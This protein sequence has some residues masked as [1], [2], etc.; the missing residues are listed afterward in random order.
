MTHDHDAMLWEALDGQTVRCNLCGHQCVIAAGKYGVCR[1][2]RNVEGKLK[3]LNYGALVALNADPIEKKPLFH[4]LPGTRSLSVAAAGCN[5]QCA[6]CQ[7]W[8]I[9]QAP[10]DGL[11]VGGATVSPAEI[12]AAAVEH[13]CPSISYTYTEPTVFFELAHDAAT[14]AKERGLKNCFVSNGFLSALAVETIAPVLDAI[15]VDLKA[16]RDATYRTIMKARLEPVLECLK[17][18]VKAGVWVEVTTLVV[19]GMNDSPEELQAIARFIA[20]QLGDSVPWHVSRFHGD[21]KMTSVPSTPLRTLEL[22]CRM[23]K[24]AGLKYIYS[25]NVA[26]QANESTYCPA[27]RE[28]LIE[29]AG[30]TVRKNRLAGGCCPGCK[31][32]IAGVWSAQ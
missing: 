19:P 24:E 12:V 3:S 4:F 22:A 29:R 11:S 13:H 5:F 27:C 26:S 9:S 25:G 23:G 17:A 15:N 6:F 28:L 18:L 8:Q 21:Y 16:F 30:F 2:R 14:L 20:E 32:P 10:R 31:T 7:N 1:V